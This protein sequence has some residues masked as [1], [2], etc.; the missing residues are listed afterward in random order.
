MG[1]TTEMYNIFEME[2]TIAIRT[3][4]RVTMVTEIIEVDPIFLLTI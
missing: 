2:T 4:T 1:T 3:S